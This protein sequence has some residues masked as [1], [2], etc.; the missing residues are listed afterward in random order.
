MPC[1]PSDTVRRLCV[2]CASSSSSSAMLPFFCGFLIDNE[3]RWDVDVCQKNLASKNP[4]PHLQYPYQPVGDDVVHDLRVSQCPSQ[5]YAWSSL[6]FDTKLFQTKKDVVGKSEAIITSPFLCKFPA[7]LAEPGIHAISLQAVAIF[8][9]NMVR[10]RRLV[11]LR[12]YK[13]ISGILLSF[14]FTA[15]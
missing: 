8:T 15:F 4:L 11:L 10:H 3:P 13:L 2:S 14:I 12:A 6:S 5:Y 7:A 1:Q 9:A